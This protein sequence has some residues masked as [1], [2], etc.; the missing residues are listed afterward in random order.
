M[1]LT[2]FQR[3]INFQLR[4][5][6]EHLETKLH[7]AEH[8]LNEAVKTDLVRYGYIILLSVKLIYRWNRNLKLT[9][10]HY[11]TAKKRLNKRM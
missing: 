9:I 4:E 8:A 1:I 6:V 2:V 10:V 7:D 3:K 5:R 11:F